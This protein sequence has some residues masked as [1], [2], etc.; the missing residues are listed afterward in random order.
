MDRVGRQRET[1]R[2]EGPDRLHHEDDDR[3]LDGQ[4]QAAQ[5]LHLGFPLAMR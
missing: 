1:P 4:P 5:H 2:E 3:E